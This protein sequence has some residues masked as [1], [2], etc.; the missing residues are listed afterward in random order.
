MLGYHKVGTPVPPAWETWYYVSEDVFAGQLSQ[1]K[2]LGWEPVDARRLLAGLDDP[3]ALPERSVLITF[4]DGFRCVLDVAAPRMR[5]LGFPGVMFVPTDYVGRT[6]EFD[7]HTSQP[8]E[9]LCSW[10][11]LRALERQGVSIQSHGAAHRAFSDL[12]PGEADH[13]LRRSKAVLEEGLQRP[14]EVFAFPYGD[15]GTDKA[16][17]SHA[18]ADAGYRAGFLYGGGPFRLPQET[19]YR[20]ARLAMGAETDLAAELGAVEVA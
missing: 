3:A 15:G 5:S 1:V 18:L 12:S 7:L 9:P 11:E 8:Q 2:E 6:N 14:V 10:D 19:P 20:L 16:T 4:D 17:M 13:E